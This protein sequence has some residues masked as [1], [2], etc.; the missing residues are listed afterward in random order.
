MLTHMFCH[1]ESTSGSSPSSSWTSRLVRILSSLGQSVTA[2]A[3]QSAKI[4]QS[5]ELAFHKTFGAKRQPVSLNHTHRGNPTMM[6]A[7]KDDDNDEQRWSNTRS[8]MIMLSPIIKCRRREWPQRFWDL[9][10]FVVV[11]A[12]VAVITD[13]MEGTCSRQSRIEGL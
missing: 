4:R 6:I 3:V 11:L 1:H 7:M 10:S 2:K 8:T 12:S 13:R 9:S 5:D